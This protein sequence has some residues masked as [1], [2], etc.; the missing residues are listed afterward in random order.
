MYD[1][2][3]VMCPVRAT[4]ASSVPGHSPDPP[5][6]WIIASK[7]FII[8]LHN[9]AIAKHDG[10]ETRRRREE[11]DDAPLEDRKSGAACCSGIGGLLG[12][13]PEFPPPY[14]WLTAALG[15]L[16]RAEEGKATIEQAF[17]VAPAV[18]DRLFRG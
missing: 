5:A 15:Q 2:V 14:R 4:V 10:G 17:A 8:P 9:C 11:G 12:G 13:S 18:F 7:P 6:G 16:G 3:P 1:R